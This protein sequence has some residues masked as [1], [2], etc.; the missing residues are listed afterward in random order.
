MKLSKSDRLTPCSAREPSSLSVISVR[1]SVV[2]IGRRSTVCRAASVVLLLL[3]GWRTAAIRALSHKDPRS[4]RGRRDRSDWLSP[5]S[6]GGWAILAAAESKI[7]GRP[8][9]YGRTDHIQIIE[10]DLLIDLA[11][12]VGR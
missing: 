6:L 10:V 4:R 2:I 11:D 7:L 8:K 9:M 3:F 1:S 12:E 5:A